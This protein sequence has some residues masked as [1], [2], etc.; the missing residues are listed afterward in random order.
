[1]VR[2]SK[3]CDESSSTVIE[4]LFAIGA[5]L[6]CVGGLIV[7]VISDELLAP[8]LSVT[9]NYNVIVSDD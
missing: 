5:V 1:L 8:S 6:F 3:L 7:I 4:S 9:V 2:G